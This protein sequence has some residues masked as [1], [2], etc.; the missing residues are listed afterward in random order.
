MVMYM[1][2]NM[3]I[4]KKYPTVTDQS[5]M[6]SMEGDPQDPSTD[7]VPGVA[8]GIC[9]ARATPQRA[10]G[11]WMAQNPGGKTRGTDGYCTGEERA[12][13]ISD[14]FR[15]KARFANLVPSCWLFAHPG[16]T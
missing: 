15:C 12:R 5:T 2:M 7:T 3:Y 8:P 9:A 1:N 4:P 16:F 11:H 13:H 6:E 14:I 10:T